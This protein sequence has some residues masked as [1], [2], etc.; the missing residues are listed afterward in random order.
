MAHSA[1]HDDGTLWVHREQSDPQ[2][3]DDIAVFR[4]DDRAEKIPYYYRDG[5]KF[6]SPTG[7]DTTP[8]ISKNWLAHTM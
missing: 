7:A 1:T 8:C 6:V 4:D 2:N 5:E 3:L